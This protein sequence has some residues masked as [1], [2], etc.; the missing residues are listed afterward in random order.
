MDIARPELKQRKRK[1]RLIISVVS[2]VIL[3]GIVAGAVALNAASPSVRRSD[4]VF[5]SVRQGEFV[6]TVRGP[7]K[8]VSSQMRWV[9]ASTDASVERLLVKP[10][11]TVKADTEIIEMSNPE[12]VDRLLAANAE[13]AAA[14]GDHSAL[15]A[16]LQADALQLKAE[17]AS[18]MGE[19]DSLQVEEQAA[20]RALDKGVLAEVDYKKIA[21]KLKQFEQNVA[22]A[23][24]RVRQSEA[25]LAAQLS[26]S[27][28]R[29]D[30][31]ASTRALR[32]SEADALRVKAG[33]DG[34]VQQISVEEGQ[35]VT[36]GANVA[37]VAKPGELIAELRIPES[38][39]SDLAA[40][41]P[42]V[43]EIGRAHVKGSVRRVNPAVEKGAILAEIDLSEA[44]PPGSRAEQS[45]DGSIVTE[46]LA[47][48]L[49][50]KRPVSVHASS[51]SPVFRMTSEGTAARVEA[52]FGKDSVD[53]IQVLG[54]L[55]KGD[56]LILSD[57]SDF[58]EVDKVSIN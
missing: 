40:G 48:A 50:V 22:I 51:T 21:I 54:G 23:Q 38:Q 13:H 58:S 29:L 57:M 37:R 49:F 8:L 17:L 26:A 16:R 14:Q 7:G 39:A 44:L 6:R 4:L 43:L 30:Q 19:R 5:D 52:R 10:G 47:D 31:L 15:Q 46:R 12:V 41:Q 2:G 32:Q 55:E 9:I 18:T 56:R 25:N 1:R 20:R 35:R 53:E 45:V 24:Q 36:A 27:R 3:V 28:M 11:A 42:A 33:M 34:V